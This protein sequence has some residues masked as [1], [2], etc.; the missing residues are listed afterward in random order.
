MRSSIVEN[1]NR[2]RH[3]HQS[4]NYHALQYYCNS[5]STSRAHT[6][7]TARSST[8]YHRIPK[9][10][11]LQ[12]ER[13]P[14]PYWLATPQSQLAS[15]HGLTRVEV[16]STW[17]IPRQSLSVD[18]NLLTLVRRN[19]IRRPCRSALRDL[20]VRRRRVRPS[21]QV[22]SRSSRGSIDGRLDG[23]KRGR[24]STSAAACTRRRDV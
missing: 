24:E 18:D 22:D 7:H 19:H 13:C 3:T 11:H 14:G 17:D 2:N 12:Y 4:H 8:Q 20:D 21:P 6:R 9:N 15:C 10:W 5:Y 1:K 16:E 23:P